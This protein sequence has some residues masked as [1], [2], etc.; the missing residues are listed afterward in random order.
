MIL[1]IFFLFGFVFKEAGLWSGV[2]V[3]LLGVDVV[4][5]VAEIAGGFLF[6]TRLMFYL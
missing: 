3:F 4:N 6:L 2:L 1:E 5:E